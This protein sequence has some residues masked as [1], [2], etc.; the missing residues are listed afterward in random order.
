MSETPQNPGPL[1]SRKRHYFYVLVFFVAAWLFIA[2]SL[3]GFIPYYIKG[4]CQCHLHCRYRNIAFLV[5]GI[6]SLFIG[7]LFSYP[8]H[9]WGL[10][11]HS[12]PHDKFV[13]L[14]RMA[15]YGKRMLGLWGIILL[16]LISGIYIGGDYFSHAFF[17][18][19]RNEQ[20]KQ[21]WGVGLHCAAARGDTADMRKRIKQGALLNSEEYY[22][23]TP[24]HMA[25]ELNQCASALVLIES[26]A[27]IN[28]KWKDYNYTPLHRAVF[29]GNNEVAFLLLEKGADMNAKLK[30]G[31]T[32]LHKVMNKII[33]LHLIEEGM[34]VNAKDN[35]SFTPL[36]H[37]VML[38]L[39]DVTDLLISKGADLNAQ[40]E[41]N[42][43]PLH[44]A[45][46]MGQIGT[47]RLLI[48]NG[49]Y[50]NTI[51]FF[52]SETWT[53][54]DKPFTE[55][56][57]AVKRNFSEIEEYLRSHGAKTGE[58]LKASNVERQRSNAEEKKK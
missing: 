44:Y 1:I 54:S 50:I 33:A 11:A 43:T 4:E 28:S 30:F 13:A 40:D 9:R 15:H 49:V 46:C 16:A 39:N 56:D 53:K 18:V 58:E 51:V 3:G 36:H 45:V 32:L 24:L 19:H 31:E 2:E 5:F 29:R 41:K 38:G 37:A 52:D 27:D 48:E 17:I 8:F 23:R 47:V 7:M 25:A 22:G 21:K 26:G 6:G 34:D 35:A 57:I 12:K 20:E 14:S 10:V 55:L 42:L